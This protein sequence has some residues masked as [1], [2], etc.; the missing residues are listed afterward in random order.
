MLVRFFDHRWSEI[1]NA[2]S[3]NAYLLLLDL[4]NAFKRLFR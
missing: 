2:K 4:V 3:A 1:N